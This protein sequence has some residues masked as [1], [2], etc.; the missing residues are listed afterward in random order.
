M[1]VSLII[2]IDV[3]DAIFKIVTPPHEMLLNYFHF[4]ALWYV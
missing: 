2:I 1:K 4:T 3:H